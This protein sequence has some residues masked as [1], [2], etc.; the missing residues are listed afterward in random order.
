MGR[1][2]GP[3]G[4]RNGM[5]RLIALLLCVQIAGC[6]HGVATVSTSTAATTGTAAAGTTAVGAQ[7]T[8]ASSGAGAIAIFA[9]AAAMMMTASTESPSGTT[10]YNANPFAAMG[11]SS[12]RPPE[13]DASRRV[14][15]QDCTKP[16]QDW[17]ANLKCK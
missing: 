8:A 9:A 10:T 15:E 14:N 5:K 12:R 17:S 6:A 16:I 7:V 1:R 4:A 3:A 13:L 2:A 11:S